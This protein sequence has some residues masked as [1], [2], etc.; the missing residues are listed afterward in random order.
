MTDLITRRAL[1]AEDDRALADI[2]RCALTRAGLEV[3]VA[4]D[5]LRALGLARH[6]RFDVIVSDYQMPKLDGESF[7]REVRKASASQEAQLFFCSAKAYELQ[8]QE[9][10]QDL[11]LAGVF[12]KPFS[13]SEL[14]TAVRQAINHG[15]TAQVGLEVGISTSELH[16]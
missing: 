5:G 9:I 3:S 11:G 1:V 2:I 10:A 16:V 4:H 7:L 14:A 6:Q 13:L 15:A 8:S 12:F